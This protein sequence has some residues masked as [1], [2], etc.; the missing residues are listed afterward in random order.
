MCVWRVLVGNPVNR[1]TS[2]ASKQGPPESLGRCRR[3]HEKENL[4]HVM[5]PMSPRH[6]Q[7][8]QI[9][10]ATPI[11]PASID[12]LS[13]PARRPSSPAPARRRA[14]HVHNTP[15]PP[16]PA[17][18]VRTR[19]TR[20]RMR[21]FSLPATHATTLSVTTRRQPPPHY[22]RRAPPPPLI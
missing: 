19:T 7:T 3:S 1:L 20:L 6:N 15:P 21:G 17:P 22:P 10:F 4:P 5:P 11:P 9:P 2:A 18:I 13:S 8:P 16:L 12:R 14:F